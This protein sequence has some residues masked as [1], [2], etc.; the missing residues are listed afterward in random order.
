MSAVQVALLL[1]LSSL[2][3]LPVNGDYKIGA[4]RYDITGPAAQIE[5]VVET[6]NAKRLNIISSL[7]MGMANPSQIA[8]GIHFRQYSR[9]FIVV[10]GSNDRNRVVFVSIDACM[11]TQIMKNKV[12]K[13]Y[14]LSR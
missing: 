9:A 4:G 10:D 14:F 12:I 6:E 11:G 8:N 13:F 2:F 5:M 3:S 7:Q 1:C